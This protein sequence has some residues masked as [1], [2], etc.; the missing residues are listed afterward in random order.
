MLSCQPHATKRS[1]LF[2]FVLSLTCSSLYSQEW[3]IHYEGDYPNGRTH[4][5]DG[6]VDREGITFLA[7][8]EGSDY[9]HPHALLLR[10]EPDGTHRALHY[11][12]Q[13][14]HTKATCLVETHEHC[15]FAACNCYGDDS[16]SLLVLLLDKELNLLAEQTYGKDPDLGPFGDCKALCDPYGNL[17]VSTS[18][19]MEN[20]FGGTED[21]GVFFKFNAQGEL[22]HQHYLMEDYPSPLFYF[23]DFHPRQLWY[24][25]ESETLLCLAPAAGGVLSFVTFDTAFNYLEEHPIWR[26]DLDKT[27]HTLFRDCYTDH[28]YSNDEALFF[29]S[30]GDADHNKLRISKVNTQ[31]EFLE[32]IRL[33]ERPDTIDDAARH[34]CMATVNDSTFYFGFHTHTVGY[35]PGACGV[36]RIN[37]RMEITGRH[38]DDDH[39]HYRSWIVLPTLDG[40]CLTVN[41]SCSWSSTANLGHPVIRKLRPEDFET[42]PCKVVSTHGEVQQRHAYP[43]PAEMILYIPLSQQPT[44]CQVLDHRGTIVSDRLVNGYGDL[45]ELDVSHL[46]PGLYLY[47]IERNNQLISQ[48]KFI[49]Q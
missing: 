38:L 36:Y 26:E 37:E 44:R 42:V 16:D 13:G 11:V 28:W 5:H 12:R 34:R 25:P 31:G 20:G 43:T 19:A 3:T 35:Y 21:H 39:D 23:K 10:I 27:D 2:I 48:E 33:N 24:R 15:L 45:L 9:H 4:F 41:D 47:R 49:K 18:V 22:L 17:F 30:R 40:G 14:C 29:S 6:L 46:R 1:L 8:E 32:F 7:G